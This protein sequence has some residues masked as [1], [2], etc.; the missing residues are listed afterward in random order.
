MKFAT[1]I[2]TAAMLVPAVFARLGD[3]EDDNIAT[4]LL[5]KGD[6]PIGNPLSNN[7]NINER[8]LYAE[9]NDDWKENDDENWAAG[10]ISETAEED[11]SSEASPLFPGET[12]KDPLKSVLVTLKCIEEEDA[13][14]ASAGYNKRAF[15]KLHNGVDTDT[16]FSFGFWTGAFVILDFILDI[17]HVAHVGPNQVSIRYVEIV[18]TT[19]GSNLFLDESAVYPFSQTFDQHE[20]ALVTVDDDCKM[21]MWDQYGD[22]Q[23]QIAVE[24]AAD[25]VVCVANPLCNGN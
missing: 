18:T 3:A 22:N 21:I 1:A 9:W 20:W 5:T 17:N 15:R 12:C 19:N 13:S 14:C 7:K 4:E 8:N 25:A 16:N 6:F 10:D 24:E 23:E 2:T 11:G